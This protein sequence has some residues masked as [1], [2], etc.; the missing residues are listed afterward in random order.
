MSCIKKFLLLSMVIFSKHRKRSQAV[1]LAG[2]WAWRMWGTHCRIWGSLT[3]A[4]S[5]CSKTSF[6]SRCPSQRRFHCVPPHRPPPCSAW[7]VRSTVRERKGV[8]AKSRE[9]WNPPL[10]RLRKNNEES[11]ASP[12]YRDWAIDE[13]WALQPTWQPSLS[14]KNSTCSLKNMVV[15]FQ[16]YGYR[17][18]CQDGST[19]KLLVFQAQSPEF[20]YHVSGLI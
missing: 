20:D 13:R 10:G 5:A 1:F 16:Y 9:A 4:P 7:R 3:V 2:P 18:G 14:S 17:K 12:S 19:R 6:P 8:W 11:E 15:E